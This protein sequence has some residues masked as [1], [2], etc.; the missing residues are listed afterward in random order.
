LPNEN[1]KRAPSDEQTELLFLQAMKHMDAT[2]KNL[3]MQ[4]CESQG[5]VTG[6]VIVGGFSQKGPAIAV[7]LK[8][9]Q[10]VSNLRAGKLLIDHGYIYEL[11]TTIRMLYETIE[12][13]LF[14]LSR[15]HADSKDDL[16]QRYLNSFFAEDQDKVQYPK[17]YDI[18]G[19]LKKLENNKRDDP[20]SWENAIGG[21]Y[22]FHSQYVH[23][24]ATR[25]MDLYDSKKDRF[26]TAGINDG[27]Y[28]AQHR[29]GLWLVCFVA[30]YCFAAVRAAFKGED[31]KSDIWAFAE[32]FFET[33]GLGAVPD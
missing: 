32:R 12:D 26:R 6:E 17:R 19:F 7:V 8:L 30:M 13:V 1:R 25:I 29:K 4:L 2:I 33:A 15:H 3:L 5:R 21:L 11:R 14:L 22:R 23:G 31:W 10:L 16:H 27:E 9:V 28:L 20:T 18:R 24:R